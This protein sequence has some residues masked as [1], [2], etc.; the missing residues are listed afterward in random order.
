MP[1]AG[2]G[3]TVED[4]AAS[5]SSSS[6][7]PERSAQPLVDGL[8]G[9]DEDSSPDDKECILSMLPPYTPGLTESRGLVDADADVVIVEERDL[10][11]VF[12]WCGWVCCSNRSSLRDGGRREPTPGDVKVLVLEAK[13]VNVEMRK[14]VLAGRHGSN[15]WCLLKCFFKFS[16]RILHYQKT[17]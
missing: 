2:V 6:S 3:T 4:A 15:R 8:A 13:E 12:A 16:L 11:W 5:S 17:N 14:D 7:V 9:E 10:V 1:G